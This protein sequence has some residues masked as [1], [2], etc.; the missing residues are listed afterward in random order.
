MRIGVLGSG[1]V[2]QT[3]ADGLLSLGHEVLLSSRTPDS[4]KLDAWVRRHAN[5]A[6]RIGDFAEAAVFG[7]MVVLATSWAG[8]H[9][10]LVLAGHPNLRGKIIIDVTNP[11]GRGLD[12]RMGL[13]VAGDDS[14]G[15]TVQR[16]LLRS[17]VV[18]AFNSVGSNLMVRPN[19]PDGPPTMFLA[20]ND[21]AAKMEVAEIARGFGYGPVDVGDIAASRFLE[22][23]SLLWAAYGEAGGSWRHALRMLDDKR[24]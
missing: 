11:H 14:G 16:W 18:K 5:A 24:A 19:L 8:T 15:E 17:R 7:E 1:P 20:G 4:D 12:G 2:G 13:T 21:A 23:L 6:A 3:L 22:P 9:N 10:A